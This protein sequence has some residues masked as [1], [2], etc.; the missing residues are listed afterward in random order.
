M[1][2][3]H[4]S[5]FFTIKSCFNSFS[6]ILLHTEKQT[7]ANKLTFYSYNRIEINDPMAPSFREQ[8]IYTCSQI[9]ISFAFD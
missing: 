1:Q 4:Q 9:A 2:H 3:K 8:P 7:L 6:N 5:T